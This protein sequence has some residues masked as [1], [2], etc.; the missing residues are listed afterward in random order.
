MRA[1][2]W[3]QKVLP[4]LLQPQSQ[5][6]TMARCQQ[7]RGSPKAHLLPGATAELSP[8]SSI[9]ASSQ[10]CS[11]C[12]YWQSPGLCQSAGPERDLQELISPLH[13]PAEKENVTEGTRITQ[14]RIWDLGQHIQLQRTLPAL[15]KAALLS[16]TC[17][18]G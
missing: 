11:M 9:L 12:C 6:T 1:T 10:A 7:V 13:L 16:W 14:S 15:S 8:C 2:V 3:H 5:D 17:L 4:P 18:R